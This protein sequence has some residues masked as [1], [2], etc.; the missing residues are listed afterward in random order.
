MDPRQREALLLVQSLRRKPEP[1]K[2]PTQPVAD[3]TNAP[4]ALDFAQLPEGK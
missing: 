2:Q 1:P 3:Q 4:K